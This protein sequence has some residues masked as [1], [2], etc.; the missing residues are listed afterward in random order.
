MRRGKTETKRV[1]RRLARELRRYT[2]AQGTGNPYATAIEGFMVLRSDCAKMPAHRLMQP[3]LCVTVQGAKWAM[4]GERRCDYRAGQAL[5]VSTEMPSRGTVSAAS[6][7][8][9]FLGLV[10]PFDLAMLHEMAETMQARWDG[11]EP[12]ETAGVFVVDLHREL[13]HCALRAVRLLQTP[14]AIPYL[15]PAILREICYWVLAGPGGE[16]IFHAVRGK[17]SER[18]IL[19]AMHTL[20]ERFA[21]PVRVEALAADAAMSLSTFHRQ[22]K[23]MTAMSPL[24]YQKQVRLLEARRAMLAEG[25]NVETA[26]LRVGY[27]SAS[28]FSREYSRMFG[29]APRRDVSALRGAVA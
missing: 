27:E 23:A 4:F 16:Q 18:P 14:E 24:Q 22:F 12:A 11:V 5:V 29:R 9:P 7:R 20:R 28:Q 3:A 10:I 26:A 21:E 15:Y 1:L 25:A 8:E 17:T 6:A 13:L 19:A 2:D